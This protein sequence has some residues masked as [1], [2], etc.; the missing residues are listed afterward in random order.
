MHPNP[1]HLTQ[2]EVLDVILLETLV[3]ILN[4]YLLYIVH[5]Y[6]KYFKAL[7]PSSSTTVQRLIWLNWD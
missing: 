3:G 2:K 4:K 7:M 5:K 6:N 1:C